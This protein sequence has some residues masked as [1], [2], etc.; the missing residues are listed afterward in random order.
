MPQVLQ[1]SRSRPA[2]SAAVLA[3]C[4]AVA[5]TPI[6]GGHDDV[7]RVVQI[8][9]T[10]VHIRRDGSD[11]PLTLNHA[12]VQRHLRD[13]ELFYTERLA[14]GVSHIGRGTGVW[15]HVRSVNNP[16][17]KGWINARF[18]VP[19]PMNSINEQTVAARPQVQPAP[20]PKP[21]P[22]PP[23]TA[24]P[25]SSLKDYMREYGEP[26]D[27]FDD[28]LSILSNVTNLLMLLIT[29]LGYLGVRRLLRLFRGQD[30]D[31]T[32]EPPPD[33]PPTPPTTPSD[34]YV[35]NFT[36]GDGFWVGSATS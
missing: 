18:T 24:Q 8:H 15:L 20:P 3:L 12:Y 11:A 32:S 31:R 9:G 21:Q 27:F 30:D 22:A 10:Y 36:Y 1:Q 17:E 23:A 19:L 29:L 25:W 7:F 16:D 28:V 33:R 4:L 13:G 6:A 34:G 14:Y 26:V 5:L 35:P 2:T